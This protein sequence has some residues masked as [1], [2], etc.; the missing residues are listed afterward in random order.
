[1]P[2]YEGTLQGIGN[3]VAIGWVVDRSDIDSRVQVALV[4]DGE[5][6][7]E[8][9]ADVARPDLAERVTGGDG[10]H[11]FQLK[12]PP[13]LRTP[14][15]RRVVVLAGPERVPLQTAASFWHRPS[16]DGA[17]SDVVFEPGGELSAAVPAPPAPAEERTAV[18]AGSWLFD[19]A[20][21]WPDEAAPDEQELERISARLRANAQRC[22]K[23][24]IVYIPALVPRKRD[25]VADGA[26]RNPDGRVAQLI[27]LLRD[28]D[29]VELVDL[30][31]VLRDAARHGSLY[32]RTDTVWNDR[33]G[34]FV[35]RALL[36]EAHKHVAALA[37]PP[38]ADLH[39]RTIPGYRGDLA[40]VNRVVAV[41]NGREPS[42]NGSRPAGEVG[43]ATAETGVAT[44]KTGVATAETGVATA[45]TGVAIDPSQLK[46]L[47]MPVEQH[48]AE[49]APIHLR[50]Y[51][52]PE[53]EEDARLAVLGEET[54]LSLVPWLAE[55]AS[56]TTFFWTEELPLLQLELELPRVVLHVMREADLLG[57]GEETA[58]RR[59]E[60]PS[61]LI[62][63]P[64][65]TTSVTTTIPPPAT[66]PST[67]TPSTITTPPVT[68]APPS[69]P[70]PLA[71]PP[72]SL[73]PPIPPGAP[74]LLPAPRPAPSERAAAS[75]L[76]T[77]TRAGRAPAFVLAA[78]IFVFSVLML[79]I[80]RKLG[81]F[82]DEWSF[83]TTRL[84][85]SPSVFLRA[86]NQ[87]PMILTILVYKLLLPV[88][89]LQHTWPYR[90]ALYCMH[91][92][93]VTLLWQLTRRRLG[94]WLALVPAA[95]LL[96]LGVA[97]EDLTLALQIN[98]LGSIA[99][100]LGALLCL[101]RRDRR[102]D[103]LA[104]ALLVTAWM[105][106][107]VGVPIALGIAVE[108]AWSRRTWRSWWVV[109]IPLG[110]YAIW[111][112]GYG[113]SSAQLENL[114]L[115]PT[116]V[117]AG[118]SATLGGIVGLQ[119][120]GE[121][122]LVAS[123][124]IVVRQLL[125]PE[126]LPPRAAMG[127]G[128]FLA[129]WAITALN[130]AQFAQPTASRYMYPAAVLALIA[131]VALLPRLPGRSSAAG[132]GARIPAR[133][134]LLLAAAI[135]GVWLSGY[136]QLLTAATNRDDV[137]AEMKAELGAVDVAGP[138]VSPAVVPDEHHAP[139]LTVAGYRNAE[140]K[141]HSR[142][143]DTVAQML[144]SDAA[145]RE[146]IDEKLRAWEGIQLTHTTAAAAAK[147]NGPAPQVLA[148]ASAI[149]ERGS[150]C[151]VLGPSLGSENHEVTIPPGR[152]LLLLPVSG[153]AEVGVK[154]RRFAA[155]FQPAITGSTSAGEPLA[156]PLA[157]D[158]STLPWRARINSAS[159]LALCLR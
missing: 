50:V 57:S 76:V 20:E 49:L 105:W 106:S 122:L 3:G 109:A 27:G 104:C 154:L 86:F 132:G 70:P 113:S 1:M 126:G 5:V 102:G 85:W 143:G 9:L 68:A 140:H 93:C 46:A 147:P 123:A 10:N 7:A 87:Q 63:P 43:V 131:A 40:E 21:E 107:S 98:Y 34:F 111:Y 80:T 66:T 91:A 6:V 35:A 83:V 141:L 159:R 116:Y 32:H 81:F 95:L 153:A 47:R 30:L 60:A 59:N 4:A 8:G 55:R 42:R 90:L 78:A 19:L 114:R 17:W 79:Y 71:A 155:G 112:L 61:A 146:L 12:L 136:N 121:I 48:L 129:F 134:W 58:E 127:V 125:R 53:R 38:F 149:L 152:T 150:A 151:V 100:G 99:A 52:T 75:P 92:L 39:L 135:G 22:R 124:A 89:G 15:R 108:L 26:D 29:E 33:G 36:K 120:L 69:P 88:A 73:L 145:D 158:D 133:G 101:E 31:P 142:A 103:R 13:A 144:A 82:Q 130:R 119:E 14:A 118:S 24:G 65:P 41:S 11:G 156:L 45:E 18:Q 16:A 44:I 67:T 94:D 96:V 56:R 139:V 84:G 23:L 148:G 54:A 115:L 2:M 117:V 97:W 137:D 28:T 51:G 77:P 25:V 72:P 74:S 138:A 37:P 64:P 157:D 110:L 62:V 128:G